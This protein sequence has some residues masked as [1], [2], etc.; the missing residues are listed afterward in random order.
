MANNLADIWAVRQTD[1]DVVI[2]QTIKFDACHVLSYA[3]ER[4][5]SHFKLSS[6][7]SQME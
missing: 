1:E 3:N 5:L 7:S 4:L 6:S 2:D